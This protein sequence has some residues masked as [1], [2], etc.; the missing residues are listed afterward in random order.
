MLDH[1]PARRQAAAARHSL[2]AAPGIIRKG[3]LLK[4]PA[5]VKLAIEAYAALQSRRQG[6][7]VYAS[8]LILQALQPWVDQILAESPSA[9]AEEL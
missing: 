7:R 4:F 8:D 5:R 3:I 6:Q 1:F 9:L 2:G